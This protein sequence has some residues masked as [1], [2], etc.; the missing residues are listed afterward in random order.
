MVDIDTI[1]EN[2]ARM[3][4]FMLLQVAAEGKHLTYDAFIVLKKEIKQRGLDTTTIEEQ[5][6][7]RIENNKEKIRGNL[8]KS[9]KD[10]TNKIWTLALESKQQGLSDIEIQ[11]VLVREGIMPE[12]AIAI[13]SELPDVT[14]YLLKN[15]AKTI[16][17]ENVWLLCLLIAIVVLVGLRATT[18]ALYFLIAMKGISSLVLVTR[19]INNKEKLNEIISVLEKEK[20]TTKTI[21]K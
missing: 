16:S 10:F 13:T 14:K 7:I 6:A 5:D 12:E 4:D 3:P 20:N 11:Q 21:N 8:A 9:A 17:D 15:A 19:A 18:W 1:R 2:Y